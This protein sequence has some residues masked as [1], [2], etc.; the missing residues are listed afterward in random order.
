MHFVHGSLFFCRYQK[1]DLQVRV[2]AS[3]D[4]SLG[5][6]KRQVSVQESSAGPTFK[7]NGNGLVLL[8]PSAVNGH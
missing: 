3:L 5:A 2:A 6:K 1:R 4:C 7:K 8:W